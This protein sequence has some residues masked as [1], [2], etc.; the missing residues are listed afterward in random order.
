MGTILGDI[1]TNMRFGCPKMMFNGGV[2]PR[3]GSV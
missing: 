1:T 3:S 2:P